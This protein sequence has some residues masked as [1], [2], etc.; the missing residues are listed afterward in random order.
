MNCSECVVTSIFER[1]VRLEFKRSSNWK[2]ML[3]F[4]F[5]Y[6]ILLWSIN[7]GLLVYD[8]MGVIKINHTK[9][10]SFIKP[11]SF[12]FDSKFSVYHCKERDEK[13]HS[14]WFRFHQ[15]EDLSGPSCIINYG[16]K[17]FKALM[18][19]NV[20]RTPNIKMNKVKALEQTLLLKRKGDLFCLAKGQTLQQM[21]LQVW[22][23]KCTT[24]FLIEGFPSLKCHSFD[25]LET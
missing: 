23:E 9:S 18:S 8:T 7:I 13:K 11:D 14:F 2:Y 6:R 22:D 19:R 17:M 16:Q 15:E 3:L 12:D 1:D 4:S 5:H 21:S 20:I 25:K 10:W 24:L